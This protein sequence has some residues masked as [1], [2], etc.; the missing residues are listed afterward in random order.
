[1]GMEPKAGEKRA[2]Q[3]EQDDRVNE[4]I[5]SSKKYCNSLSP[6]TLITE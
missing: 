6:C 1:M 4:Q 3:G 2:E 5:S